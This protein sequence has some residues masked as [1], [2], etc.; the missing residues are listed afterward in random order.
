MANWQDSK[1]CVC[2]EILKKL[3]IKIALIWKPSD[4]RKLNFFVFFLFLK[5][6]WRISTKS[7]HYNHQKWG[8]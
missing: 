8:Q 3:Q 2:S 7:K 5:N 4:P 6:L 1:L